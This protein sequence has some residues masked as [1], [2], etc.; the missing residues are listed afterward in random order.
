MEDHSRENIL[1]EG[2]QSHRFYE[3]CGSRC[4]VTSFEAIVRGFEGQTSD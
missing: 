1:I 4:G 2:R 3:S